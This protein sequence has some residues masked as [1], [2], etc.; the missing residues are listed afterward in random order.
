MLK[1][2]CLNGYQIILG[3]ISEDSENKHC[4]HKSFRNKKRSQDLQRNYERQCKF[5]IEEPASEIIT[6]APNFD[7]EGEENGRC[8]SLPPIL[9]FK[10]CA[11]YV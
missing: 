7:E 2:D 3:S 5:R 9:A 8:E 11:F 6:S 1:W 10:V 4:N